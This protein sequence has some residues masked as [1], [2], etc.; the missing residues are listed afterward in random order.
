[1]VV[2]DGSRWQ[3][4]QDD[5]YIASETRRDSDVQSSSS[6]DSQWAA[7]EHTD[8]CSRAVDRC[9]RYLLVLT[10]EAYAALLRWWRVG[11]GE[12]PEAVNAS[13]ARM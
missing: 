4:R 11:E 3:T 10:A 8:A 12:R 5:D 6:A 13:R 7:D 9:V 2:V 1:M